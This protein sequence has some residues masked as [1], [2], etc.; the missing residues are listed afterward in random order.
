VTYDPDEYMRTLR[1]RES[2]RVNVDEPRAGAKDARPPALPFQT[3]AEA[4]AEVDSAGPRRFLIRGIWPAGVHGVHAAEM[5]AQ[6]TWNG[7]D[8]VAS[9]TDWLGAYP[10][11]DPGSVIFFIGE[12]GK[13]NIIRRLRSICASRGLR[14]EDLPIWLCVRSPRL[15]DAQ[16]MALFDQQVQAVRPKLVILDPLYLSVGSANGTD[17][18]TVGQ[19]LERPQHVCE[20]AGAALFVVTHTN[21]KEGR[22]AG[23][24]T[25]AGPAEWGRVLI[26][27]TVTSKATNAETLETTVITELDIAGGEVPER[28][29]KIRRRIYSDDPDDLDSAL[30]YSVDALAADAP[31]EAN[32]HGLGPAADKLLEA[33]E[34]AGGGTGMELV[35]RIKERHGHGL[36]RKTWS[37][38][39]NAL[40]T[41]GL[42]CGIEP[43]P[44]LAKV[45][46]LSP[47]PRDTPGDTLHTP[48]HPAT[49][50][51]RGGTGIG[52]TPPPAGMNG[53]RP[54]KSA[55]GMDDW[56][57]RLSSQYGPGRP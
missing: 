22:G 14:L 35:D 55:P 38:K 49:P 20:V 54:D 10:I 34:T 17:L 31:T 44:G 27:G 46:T 40:E 37:E 3:I 12:G 21:R 47:L 11:D 39:L 23:R 53:S 16:H 56:G 48:C 57:A 30:H 42:C 50:P 33:L 1:A 7:C 5:K 2:A 32:G 43:R 8:L 51:Y 26:V 4:C 9:E 13:P 15:Q 25:G 41:A 52:G 29:V 18:S 19:V 24:I 36:S 45:W 6:K 28:M